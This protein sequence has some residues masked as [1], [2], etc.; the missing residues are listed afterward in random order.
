MNPGMLRCLILLGLFAFPLL[1]QA[2]DDSPDIYLNTTALPETTAEDDMV[3]GWADLHAHQFANLGFG[4]KLVVGSPSGVPNYALRDNYG[5]GAPHGVDDQCIIS[6]L[7]ICVLKLSGDPIGDMLRT[8]NPKGHHNRQGYPSFNGWPAWNTFDH[9]TM[10]YKWVQR[11]FLGGQ[12]LMVMLAVS[13]ELLCKVHNEVNGF[14]GNCKD[15]LAVD[16]QLAAIRNMERYVDRQ[17]DGLLNGSGWY[18]VATSAEQARSIINNGAMAVVMGIEVDT[19]FSC[20]KGS[21]CTEQ[22]INTKLDNYHSLGVRHVFPMHVFDNGFGGAAVYDDAMFNLGNKVLNGSYF[23]VQECTEGNDFKLKQVP[24][25]LQ[26]LAM[27]LLKGPFPSQPN[28]PAGLSSHC[29]KRGLTAAGGHLLNGLMERGMLIDVDHMSNLMFDEVLQIAIDN[30]YPLVASHSTPLGITRAGSKAEGRRTDAQL[31]AIHDLG[32]MVALNLSSKPRSAL[33]QYDASVPFTCSY[34]AQGWIQSYL[35]ATDLMQGNGLLAS[36][37]MGTDFNGFVSAPAPRFGSSPCGSTAPTGSVGAKVQYPFAAHGKAGNFSPQQSAGRTFN[38]NQDGLAHVGLLPDFIEE[39]KVL[40]VSEARL[41]PLFRSAEK[42]LQMWEKAE[43]IAFPEAPEPEPSAQVLIFTS[44]EPVANGWINGELDITLELEESQEGTSIF[45]E[46]SGATSLA[47]T[48]S[49]S[50]AMITLSTSGETV[51]NY[52]SYNLESDVQSETSTVLFKIDNTPP[53]VGVSSVAGNDN[54]W[55]MQDVEVFLDAIDLESGVNFIRY[56]VNGGDPLTA[57]GASFSLTISEEGTTVIEAIAV[58]FTNKSS[59]PVELVINLDKT[60]PEL[61]CSSTPDRLWP[62]N[63]KMVEILNTV[64]FTDSG[65]GQGNDVLLFSLSTDQEPEASAS[66]KS[67]KQKSEKS[68]KQKSEKSSKTR[69]L[70]A[71]WDLGGFDLTGELLAKKSE[72]EKADRLYT[73]IYTGADL[74]GNTASCETTVLVPHS[75]SNSSKKS[76]KEG[77]DKS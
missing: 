68:A 71:G 1:V 69:S 9:Q 20:S 70:I 42:Y 29:N 28:Y 50:P 27:L 67:A 26:F 17:D 5:M 61:S 6:L 65:S 57:E 25:D 30:D 32:G 59:E 14:R 64:V 72:I 63:N 41:E 7:F 51:L 35:Y 49:V 4:G 54:G 15:M 8:G 77:K 13:N 46:V 53:E 44:Q 12:K 45:Y 66:E 39:L 33:K 18:K 24:L 60:S 3:W 47:L 19:L 21:A 34:S 40:G 52:Y 2:A 37:G 73:M 36:V 74:A 58:D 55:H 43:S 48:E 62:P 16:I 31:K 10:Y 23:K 56:S 22:Q 38:I 75:N 76:E 11:A